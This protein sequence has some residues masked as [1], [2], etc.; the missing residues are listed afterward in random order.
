M[1]IYVL[2]TQPKEK[3]LDSRFIWWIPLV[4]ALFF[5][6]CSSVELWPFNGKNGSPEVR[7]PENSTAYQC[8]GGKRFF[9]RLIDNGAAAW[10]IYPDREVSLAKMSGAGTRYSNG[11]ALLDMS[12]VEVT[13]ADGTAISYTGC[14]VAK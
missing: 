13:L 11:M 3:R 6:A 2:E 7:T 14:K 4:A 1:A 9:V 10:L 5:S 8:N 12:G